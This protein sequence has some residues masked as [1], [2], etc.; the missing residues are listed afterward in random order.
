MAAEATKKLEVQDYM[1]D[2]KRADPLLILRR[3]EK[4]LP[5]L[6]GPALAYLQARLETV[7]GLVEKQE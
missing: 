2:E 7:R 5:L 4:L 1:D 3:I 6:D